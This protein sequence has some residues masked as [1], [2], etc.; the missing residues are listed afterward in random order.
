MQTPMLNPFKDTNWNPDLGERRKFARSLIIGLPCIALLLLVT[1]RLHASVWN[2]NP[3]LIIG[4]AGFGLGVL[5]LLLPSIAKPFY[6]VWYF[7]ACC[8]GIVVGNVLLALAFYVFVTGVGLLKRAFGGGTFRKNVDRTAST[9]WQDAEQPKD[10]Q[11]YYRQ[12]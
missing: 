10:P 1:G 9:Y 2:F 5:L 8:V 4:G 12:Y 11:R 6:L 7:L 3:P